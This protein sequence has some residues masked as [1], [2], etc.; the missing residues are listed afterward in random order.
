MDREISQKSINIAISAYLMLFVSW[1]FLFN[2]NE[3]VDNPFVRGHIKKAIVIH[4]LIIL[5]YIVFV[6]FSFLYQIRIFSFGLNDILAKIGFLLIWV[7]LVRWIFS[8]LNKKELKVSESINFIKWVSLDINNDQVFDEKDKF[9]ILVSY[10]PFVWYITSS[11]YKNEKIG[12]ILKL[13]LLA[14]AIISLVYIA[15]YVNLAALLLLISLAFSIFSIVWLYVR[16][17]LVLVNL[18]GFFSPNVLVKSLKILA[19]Y[20]YFY[21]KWDF[22]EFKVLEA[23]RNEKEVKIKEEDL[24]SLEPLAELKIPKWLIYVPIIN[25][26]FFFQKKNKYL[27][28]IRNGLVLSIIFVI[29]L[30]SSLLHMAPSSLILL[31]LFPICF[32]EW[33]LFT[34]YYKMPFIYEIY[35]TF[36]YLKNLFHTWRKKV[37]ENSVVQEVSLKV[38]EEK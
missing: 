3:Y 22:K 18:P 30:I 13:N 21:F 26:L 6:H 27:F 14:T 10:I 11:K 20:V 25:F 34:P 7:L 38:G 19:K 36:I 2:K 17:E 29:F 1:L 37:K 15:N 16:D 8:A 28:H 5:N 12:K 33:M 23:E 9:T 35:D 24:K 31:F 32:G 4:L